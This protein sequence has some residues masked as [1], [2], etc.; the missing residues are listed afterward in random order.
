MAGPRP[1]VLLTRPADRA[2]L[3]AA[4]LDQLGIDTLIWPILNIQPV[5]ATAPAVNGAQAILLTSPRAAEALP[6]P[7][8]DLSSVPTFCV[9]IATMAAARTVGFT[10]TY[11]ADGDAGDLAA[12]VNETLTTDNGPLLY[13]RGRDVARDMLSL[14]HI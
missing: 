9:G 6:Q 7:I 11:D 12:L 4:E 3:L 5:L 13:L 1:L 10:N 2:A 8:G 14:I